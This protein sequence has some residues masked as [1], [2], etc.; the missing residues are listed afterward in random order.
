MA[1]F[2][3]IVCVH[4]I[5]SI[6]KQKYPAEGYGIAVIHII[7]SKLEKSPYEKAQHGGVTCYFSNDLRND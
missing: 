7:K 4:D 2:A 5:K 1:A 3:A 6:T